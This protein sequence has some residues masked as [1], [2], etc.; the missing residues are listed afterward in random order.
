MRQISARKLKVET[1][2]EQAGPHLWSMGF[3]RLTRSLSSV[4]EKAKEMSA[5]VKQEDM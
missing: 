1:S 2:S 5:Q 3:G 4:L